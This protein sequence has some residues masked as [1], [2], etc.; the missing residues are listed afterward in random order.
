MFRWTSL[1]TAKLL[2]GVHSFHFDAH[3]TAQPGV[4]R[5][6]QTE[7]HAGYL[8]FLASPWLLGR[9]MASLFAEFNE[10]LRKRV[11]SLQKE[12]E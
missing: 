9:L 4:T 11:E 8:A 5:F 1:P 3:D 10:A 2:T 6:R 12:A 7:T